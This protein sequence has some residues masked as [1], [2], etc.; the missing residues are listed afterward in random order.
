M[1]KIIS[2]T[3]L[4]AFFLSFSGMSQEMN[5]D[6]ILSRYYKAIG[7]VHIKE[8]KTLTMT[9]KSTAQGMEI[10]L[11][12]YVKRPG[13]IRIEVEVQGNKMIQVLDGMT[14]WTVVPWSGSTDPQDMT[15]DQIKGMKEQADFE[16]SLYNWK[17]KGHKVELVGKEDMDGTPVYKL[18]AILADE[19]IE[20]Y[21]IDA[22]NFVPLKVSTVV[23]IQGNETESESYPSNYKDVSGAMMPFALEN[24]F[25]GQSVSHVVMEK[26]EINKEMDDNL[27]IKPAKK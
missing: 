26:Y 14:G 19:N 27:F 15:P 11:T 5:L 6:E 7:L 18:K 23:K 25:K 24:K 4:L 16:G 22:E 17:E 9:G 3:I 10:P 21:Y 13:K 8:W 12:I 20:T 2:I 1:K